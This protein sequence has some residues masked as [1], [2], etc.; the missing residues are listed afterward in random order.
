VPAA[1]TWKIRKS[2]TIEYLHSLASGD[3]RIIALADKLSNI[4]ASW[5]DFQV[6]GDAMWE[7]FN[8]PDK[9][10]QAWYYRSVRDALGY[11]QDAEAWKEFSAL[12]DRLFDKSVPPSF[13]S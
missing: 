8:M 1:E 11:L 10:M 13:F 6:H 9:V 3:E 5:R 12:V 7:K 2:E 4:R